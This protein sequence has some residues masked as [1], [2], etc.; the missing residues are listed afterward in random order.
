M[1]RRPRSSML[2]FQRATG[3]DAAL[4]S[5]SEPGAL[6][7]RQVGMLEDQ[8]TKDDRVIRD[9]RNDA[10]DRTEELAATQRKLIALRDQSDAAAAAGAARPA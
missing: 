3:E 1:P 9:L 4:R 8:C 5:G 6:R 2:A 7:R 10:A